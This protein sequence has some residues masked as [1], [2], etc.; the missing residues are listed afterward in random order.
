MIIGP[1]EAKDILVEASDA[2]EGIFDREI[3]D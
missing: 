1:N 2:T 3:I